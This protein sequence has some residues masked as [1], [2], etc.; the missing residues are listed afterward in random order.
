[1]AAPLAFTRSSHDG[2][3]AIASLTA[4][5]ERVDRYRQLRQRAGGRVQRK[6]AGGIEPAAVHPRP[7]RPVAPAAAAAS[8]RLVEGGGHSW[9]R[10]LRVVA[11]TRRSLPEIC[12]S[13]AMGLYKDLW[14]VDAKT[15]RDV[16]RSRNHVRERFVAQNGAPTRPAE[17]PEEVT[18]YNLVRRLAFRTRDRAA[19]VTATHTRALEG[20]RAS[21]NSAIR[22]PS[23]ADLE[24]SVELSP[25]RWINL[26][27]QAKRLYPN[28]RY[29]HWSAGQIRHLVAYAGNRWTPAMLLYNIPRSPFPDP[30]TR[31]WVDM[32]ECCETSLQ[33]H[34]W[35]W[36]RWLPP[37]HRSPLTCTVVILQAPLDQRLNR[38]HP[39]ASTV[40]QFAMTLACLA[41]PNNGIPL[42]LTTTATEAYKLV[43]VPAAE[44]PQDEPTAAEPDSDQV[45][46]TS[47]ALYS[48][49]IPYEEEEE[50]RAAQDRPRRPGNR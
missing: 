23:G 14:W 28:G 5:P 37:D 45:I 43:T 19:V 21:P 24:L 26:L 35:L 9:L 42:A 25:G 46:E 36:P 38:D 16:I 50:E 6:T 11:C 8:D 12:Q 13:R 2:S 20:G 34:G 39:D 48:I 4:P 31:G 3:M 27:L 17:Q 22:P 7:A 29:E 10:S 30:A 40:N 18:T 47:P 49:V 32:G 33:T 44:R 1:M 15:R 41:C